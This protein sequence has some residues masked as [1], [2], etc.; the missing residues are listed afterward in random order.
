MVKVK[1]CCISSHEEAALALRAG[2][3]ALGLVGHMPS[4]PGVVADEIARDIARAVPRH[5]DTF[6][7]SSETKAADIIDHVRYCETNTV[8]IVQHID[9][10][11]YKMIRAKLPAIKLVQVIHIEDESALDLIEIYAPFIDAYLLDS[12]RPSLGEGAL[13][14]GGTGRTHD[15]NISAAFVKRAPKPV[16]LAGGLMPDNVQSAIKT[17]KPYGVDLCSGIRTDDQL[18][19]EKC[20]YQTS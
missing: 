17:V 5:I 19:E 1:I 3:D 2:A 12:G 7:L 6:L 20:E 10:Q 9:P 14:L 8:Q 13:E 18:D 15:W 11:E 16:Y 4:G